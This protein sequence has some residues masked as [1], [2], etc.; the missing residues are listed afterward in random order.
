MVDRMAKAIA[1]LAPPEKDGGQEGKAGDEV[2]ARRGAVT[3][4]RRY[5]RCG[6]EG[7]VHRLGLRHSTPRSVDCA[8][9]SAT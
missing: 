5:S 1:H 2:D 3:V 7:A 8:Y 4:T 9:A 6:A